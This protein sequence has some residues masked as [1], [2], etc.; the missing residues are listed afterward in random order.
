MYLNNLQTIINYPSPSKIFIRGYDLE[1]YNDP[2]IFI[3][4]SVKGNCFYCNPVDWSERRET[5]AGVRDRGDPAG[6]LASRRL[7]EPA[8]GKRSAW[9]GN[10]QSS[11]K[12]PNYKK[13][14][15][16]SRK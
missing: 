14:K 15:D 16:Y 11:L 3:I 1:K 12:Q 8:R 10:Q 4:G 5:P 7:P 13:Q 2:F 9:S 6:A